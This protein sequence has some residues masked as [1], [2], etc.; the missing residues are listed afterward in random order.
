MPKMTGIEMIGKLRS[1][2]MAVPVIMATRHL[3]IQEFVRKPW[4]KPDAMLQRP[5][6]ND[7]LLMTV[8]DVLN[9]DEGGDGRPETLLPVYL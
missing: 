6:S 5:F 9:K 4:L 3:P 1:A 8:K 2:N 7:E